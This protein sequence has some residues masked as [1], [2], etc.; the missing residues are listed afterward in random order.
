MVLIQLL[1]KEKI[2]AILSLELI[3]KNAMKLSRRL[4]KKITDERVQT[5]LREA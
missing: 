3:E 5:V 4:S 2:I 1:F